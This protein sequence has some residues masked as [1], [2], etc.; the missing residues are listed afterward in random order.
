MADA[1]KPDTS[2]HAVKFLF[3][4][5][6][7][8][9]ILALFWFLT[10]GH[11]QIAKDRTNVTV[12]D[13]SGHIVRELASDKNR[14]YPKNPTNPST[15]IE[16]SKG[17]NQNLTD[18]RYASTTNKSP[19]FRL[20]TLETGNVYSNSA[21]DQY[22]MIRADQDLQKPIVVSGWRLVSIES[23]A[24]ATIPEGLILPF[25][26]SYNNANEKIALRGG[27]KA[28]INTARSPNGYSF[29]T[30][31]CTGYFQQ[32]NDFRPSLSYSCPR[33]SDEP[34]PE[35][36]NNL[37][38]N[39]LDYIRSFPQCRTLTTALPPGLAIECQNFINDHAGYSPCIQNHKTDKDFYGKEWRI[40]LNHSDL[41]WKDRR[42]TIRLLDENG[43]TVDELRYGY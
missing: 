4:F 5:L 38:D 34:L 6:G 37:K 14:P 30:N 43:K 9:V 20:L 36:P 41:L 32:F 26:E 25:S 11:N 18:P 39:C 15:P 35:R 29:L 2:G 19:F 16:V 13:G 7:A 42:E 8:L 24:S 12:T 33:L 27:D 3:E 31:K 28:Y 40:Y 1:K 17:G 23:G 10:R 21:K 22:I